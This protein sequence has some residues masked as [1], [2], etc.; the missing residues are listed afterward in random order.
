[1]KIGIKVKSIICSR[2]KEENFHLCDHFSSEKKGLSVERK[3][4]VH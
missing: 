4:S 1:M 3:S 2:K